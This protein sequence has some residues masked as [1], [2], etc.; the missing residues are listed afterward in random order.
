MFARDPGAAN[1]IVAAAAVLAGGLQSNPLVAMFAG[2]NGIAPNEV[3]VGGQGPALSVFSAASL[4]SQPAQIGNVDDA[5]Q[6]LA[7]SGASLLVTGTG[8]IDDIATRSLWVAARQQ[9][10]PSVALLDSADNCEVRFNLDDGQRP[11]RVVAPNAAAVSRLA[12]LGFADADVVLID[13]LHHARLRQTVMAGRAP[14]RSQWG[15]DADT[16][17]ILFVSEN[18]SEAREMGRVV[19][20][21]EFELLERL[22]AE[23]TDAFRVGQTQAV[24]V[25]RPHPRDRAGKYERFCRASDPRVIVSAAGSPVEAISGADLV[26]GMRSALLDEAQILG[27]PVRRL[28]DQV[29]V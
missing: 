19:A 4:D 15:A 3:S 27:R 25:V 10:I 23:S 24:I 21:D 1:H 12:E 26:A 14:M 20:F 17:V 7:N 22:I 28:L 9:N 5:S 16:H 11:D 18:A 2:F 8:D 29:S 13:N 6:L